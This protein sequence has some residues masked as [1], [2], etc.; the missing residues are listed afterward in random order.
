MAGQAFH[1][2]LAPEAAQGPA[3]GLA[4]GERIGVVY[5]ARDPV[6]SCACDVSAMTTASDWWRTL[7]VALALAAILALVIGLGVPG[8]LGRL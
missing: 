2:G 8:A 5:D 3:V 1:G 7:V 4:V 6:L